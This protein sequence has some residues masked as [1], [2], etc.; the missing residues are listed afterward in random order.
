M[1]VKIAPDLTEPAI[2]ELL[3]VCLAR[4]AAGVIATNTTLARDGLAPVDRA[5]GAET[6][7]PPVARSPTAPARWSPSCTGRPTADYR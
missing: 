2:A 1:L 3:E 7:G 5:R 6:G 4:G